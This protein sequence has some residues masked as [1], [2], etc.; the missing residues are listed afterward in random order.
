MQS[1]KVQTICGFCHTNCGM[2]VE[3]ARGRIVS[4]R[5]AAGHPANRGYLCPKG[6]AAAE[7]VHAPD[8]ITHP[9]KRTSSGSFVRVSWDEALDAIAQKLTS[10]RARYGPESLFLATGAPVTEATRDGFKQF[11][12]EF[13]SPNSI[14]VGNICQ[15][16]R[17]T[18]LSSVYGR[19]S[20]PDLP[21]AE[22][23]IYWGANP[24]ASMR[25]GRY[26]AYGQFD[27]A[28]SEA[29][30]QGGRLIV[31]DPARTRFAAEADEWVRIRPGTD[32]ALALAMLHVI[33]GEGLVDQDFVDNHTVGFEQLAEHVRAHSPE[34]AATITGVEAE[35]IRKLARTY[36][37]V[38][39][40]CI[41]DGNGFDM[42][43]NVVQTVRA[44]GLLQAVAGKVDAPGGNVFYPW[45]RQAPYPTTKVEAK[46]LSADK[47]PL[48]PFVPF[49]E[50]VEALLTGEPYLPGALICSHTNPLLIYADETRTRR[51]LE[52][53]ELLVV[54]DLFMTATAAAADFIL[55]DASDFE[56]MGYRAYASSEGGVLALRQKAIDP[57]GE[58][59]SVFWAERELARRLGFE[60]YAWETEEE[61][62]NYRIGPSG[63]SAAELSQVSAK[64]VTPAMKYYKHRERGFSTPSGK[65]ELYSERYQQ[66]GY[67][68]M[69]TFRPPSDGS[70]P[71]ETYPLVGSSR[72]PAEF[73]HTKFRNCPSLRKLMPEPL[74][75]IHPLDASSSGVVDGSLAEVT[76]P[77]GSIRLKVRVS[78]E[79]QEGWALI[80]F[81]WGNPGDG[82]ANIN[83]LTPTHPND[84]IVGATPNR[85]FPIR[86][87]PFQG[88]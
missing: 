76:S 43:P 75:W 63:V 55:P 65:A 29:R 83:F 42:Y 50:F 26:A 77:Q 22:L 6:Y 4:V 31:I 58:C 78:E 88:D 35:T 67:D 73:V 66:H 68:P 72:R 39:A 40:A 46:R 13:G 3:V 16:P 11:L 15:F 87:R 2:E 23:M 20:E 24:P 14:T 32:M 45:P 86:V 12:A 7:V 52:K 54:C 61:W 9:L 19:L 69:P 84:P 36:G 64:V 17:I 53:L 74:L 57:P 5:G 27:T 82:G 79:F 59:R 49:Q 1:K 30:D 71:S 10:I 62:V 44:V 38:K 47:Y 37:S 25:P 33:I 81:G 21:R 80:D 8:R 60:G 18:G 70:Y 34:W 28:I 51:V 41:Q 48:F 85:H 56:R